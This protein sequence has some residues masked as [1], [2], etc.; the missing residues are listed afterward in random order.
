MSDVDSSICLFSLRGKSD[1]PVSL[2]VADADMH[3]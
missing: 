2:C 1:G 3:L